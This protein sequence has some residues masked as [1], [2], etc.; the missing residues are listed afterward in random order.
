[1]Y[2]NVR[3]RPYLPGHNVEILSGGEPYFRSLIRL[4]DEARESVF[5][6]VYILEADSTGTEVLNRL[7]EADRRGVSV[8]LLVDGFGSFGLFR[9]VDKLLE[10]TTI[11]HRYFA[12]VPFDTLRQ[13]ARRLHIKV[14]VA[15]GRAAI[16]GGIN[17]SDRYRGD[18]QTRPWLDFALSFRGPLCGVVRNVC[19]DIYTRKVVRKKHLEGAVASWVAAGNR[20]ES[21]VRLRL[22][23]NDWLRGRNDI[24]R[25]YR[26]SIRTAQEEL[27]ILNSYFIPSVRLLRLMIRA[28]K[29]GCKVTLLLSA[30]SDV[31][32]VKAAI[33]YLYARLLKSGIRIFEYQPAVLH[34]KVF[35]ADRKWCTIGSHNLNH[36]SEFFSM[37]MN[38]DIDDSTVSG[39]LAEVLDRL[40][41]EESLEVLPVEFSK[42]RNRWVRFGDYIA[43]RSIRATRWLFSLF[44][45]HHPFQA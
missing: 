10:G 4:I 43:F 44:G 9:R 13:P 30:Q 8:Y 33:R 28:S 6:Q 17:I 41:V 37:E 22:S 27:T 39:S 20:S 15:D 24:S 42:T 26:H 34:A 14:C 18:A 40:L 7:V 36:L 11:N 23:V 29:R 1:M 45:R 12:A 5:L 31:P 25:A 32:V 21:P 16:V 19:E 3:P 35:V 2:R 38:V